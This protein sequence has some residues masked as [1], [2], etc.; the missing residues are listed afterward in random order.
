MVTQI[1]IRATKNRKQFVENYM[2]QKIPNAHVVYDEE[3]KRDNSAF[4]KLLSELK[5]NSIIIEDDQFISDNFNEESSKLIEKYPDNVICFSQ[6]ITLH[7]NHILIGLNN[8]DI[9]TTFAL[10]IPIKVAHYFAKWYEEQT[11]I[12][13]EYYG[14]ALAAYLKQI[15]SQIYFCSE[16]LTGHD[17][18]QSS[19]IGHNSRQL[20]IS[21]NFDYKKAYKQYCEITGKE[22]PIK[23]LLLSNKLK[24]YDKRT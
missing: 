19:T 14:N 21:A 20:Y 2:L 12:W 9:L 3:L 13:H 24:L 18:S 15:N 6:L 5:E 7:D 4:V 22:D 17:I 1:I 8:T 16:S 10:Y 23:Y 11:N